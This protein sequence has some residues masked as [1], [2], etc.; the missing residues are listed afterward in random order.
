MNMTLIFKVFTDT[1]PILSASVLRTAMTH[2]AK[3]EQFN[4]TSFKGR[5]A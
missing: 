2:T 5:Q 1:S 3:M 4:G